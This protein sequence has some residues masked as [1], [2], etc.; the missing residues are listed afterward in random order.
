VKLVNALAGSVY[1]LYDM[2]PKVAAIYVK[3]QRP[4]NKYNVLL[5]AVN[6][7]KQMRQ[8]K[9]SQVLRVVACA[10]IKYYDVYKCSIHIKLNN[11]K[12]EIIKSIDYSKITF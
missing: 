1:L 8:Q 2:L 6:A 5:K 11:M 12:A 7:G 3:Y 4:D 9:D 10:A